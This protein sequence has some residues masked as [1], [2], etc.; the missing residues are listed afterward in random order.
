MAGSFRKVLRSLDFQGGSL[1]DCHVCLQCHCETRFCPYGAVVVMV[2]YIIS[3]E[4]LQL[5]NDISL[6]ACYATTELRPPR[7]LYHKWGDLATRASCE[8]GTLVVQ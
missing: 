8:L 4:T 7:L 5:P 6:S 1:V 3:G 2:D